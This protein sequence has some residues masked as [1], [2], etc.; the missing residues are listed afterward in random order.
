MNSRLAGI[1]RELLKKQLTPGKKLFINNNKLF[2][3]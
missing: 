3:F 2:F 1:Q